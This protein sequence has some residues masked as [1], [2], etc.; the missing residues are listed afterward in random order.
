MP[1]LLGN[2]NGEPSRPVTILEGIKRVAGADVEVNYL[3][4]CPLVLR[5]GES[6]GQAKKMIEDATAAA[7]SADVVIYV[8]GISPDLEGEEF[9]GV[10]LYDGFSGGDR[11]RIELPPVQEDLIRALHGTGKPVVFVNCSGSAVAMPWQAENLPAILQA[12]YPGEQ[13]GRAVGDIL[14][15]DANP[16]AGCRSR[17]TKRPPIC[18]TLKNTR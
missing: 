7:K 6:D 11:S 5:K 4:G 1:L 17:F 8:G 14:F 10:S 2:Y 12:W 9:G 3:P 18:L 16:S 13:G 15:G